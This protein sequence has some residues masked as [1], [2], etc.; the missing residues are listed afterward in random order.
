MSGR[1]SSETTVAGQGRHG[2]H[3]LGRSALGRE[4]RNLGSGCSDALEA[5]WLRWRLSRRSPSTGGCRLSGLTEA[6]DCLQSAR[7]GGEGTPRPIARFDLGGHVVG[8]AG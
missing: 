2:T 3:K 8:E 6:V 4:A 1:T 7:R 5:A